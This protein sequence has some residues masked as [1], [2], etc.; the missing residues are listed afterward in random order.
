MLQEKSSTKTTALSTE[1]NI[2]E[3]AAIDLGSNSF[4][5]IIARIINGSVQILSRLKQKVQLANGL[6]EHNELSQEAISRGVNCLD[7]FAKRL[8]GFDPQNINVVGTYTLRRATNNQTFLKQAQQVFPYPINII[9]GKEEAKTIY[10]GVSHTQPEQG[11]KFV[12][13]I[14]GGSTEMVI[15]DNFQPIIAESRHMGCVS[16]AQKYFPNGQISPEN[17]QKAKQSALDKIEDLAFE[18]NQLGWQY[19]LGSSGTIKT[20]HQVIIANLSADGIITAQHLEKLVQKV[21]AVSHFNQLNLSGLNPDRTDVFV[22]GLAILTAIFET[23]NIQTMRYSDGALREGIIYSLEKSFQ[24]CDI[25]Q[26]TAT[27]LI[28]QFNIDEIQSKQVFLSTL[29]LA[30]QCWYWENK[31]QEKEIK[32]ILY[33]AAKLHEVG[34]T[35]NH[36]NLQKHSAYILK[37][38]ELPGFDN[39]Q[40]HLLSTL[41]RYQIQYFKLSDLPNFTRYKQKDILQLICLLRLAIILNKARQ[42]TEHTNKISLKINR[43]LNK[44]SLIFEKDYL[45]KNPLIKNDLSAEKDFLNSLK[46]KLNFK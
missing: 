25:R 18:Y 14:G 39:D 38:I 33:W 44:W 28:K 42:A 19:V 24:V 3:I 32:E 9:S 20:V 41:T 23:F 2:R 37:N 6:D 15:G 43:T 36:N 17:F 11:R 5:M 22:P 30:K 29:L 46:L 35:I 7:L 12:V 10:A 34:I 1:N 31:S 8:R 27:G 40:Q 21:L 13:D 45:E 16:F 4:H 26:R